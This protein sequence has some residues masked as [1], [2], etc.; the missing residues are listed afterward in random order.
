M[1]NKFPILI[2]ED[3]KALN[4]LIKIKLEELGY[5]VYQA[6]DID[7]AY[8]IFL[9][10]EKLLLLLDYKLGNESCSVLLSKLGKIQEQLYFI[11][12]SGHGDE[13][14][15][16]EMMKLGAR[17]YIVKDTNIVELLPN[18]IERIVKQ[19][20][21]ETEFSK[22]KESLEK[23][24]QKFRNL[25]EKSRDAILILDL[26]GN[27]IDANL[28]S[29]RKLSYEKEQLL[30]KDIQ[31]LVSQKESANI[32]KIFDNESARFDITLEKKDKKSFL[33]EISASQYSIDNDTLI[34]CIIRD[35]TKRKLSEQKLRKTIKEKDLLLKEVHH[36]VKNNM[37]IISS[38][39]T[40]QLNS[41]NNKHYYELFKVSQNRIHALSLIH[42][43]LYKT[44]GLDSIDFSK[45]ISRYISNTKKTYNEYV[46]RIKI[47]IEIEPLILGID[48]AIPLSLILNELL[49]NSFKYAFPGNKKG[50]I[51]LVFKRN[52]KSYYLKVNDNGVGFTTNTTSREN[53]TVGLKLVNELIKQING[54]IECT[55]NNGVAYLITFERD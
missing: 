22:T 15:A 52:Q 5:I 17:D 30:K 6:Y 50:K 34:Q 1:I 49:M 26:Q 55:N 38:I 16:V 29:L 47:N 14:L 48:S 27:I 31:S 24:E 37:Q 28:K 33:A 23:S 44:N 41:I 46:S 19:V 42:E 39:L 43:L 21:V 36:R 7:S 2:V 10:N 3:D 25:F 8:K 13:K 4:K 9:N 12:M 51:D 20:D 53:D 54:R 32:T 40:L 35:I 11:I 18:I 45:F